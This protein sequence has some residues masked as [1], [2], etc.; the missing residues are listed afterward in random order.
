MDRL[1]PCPFCGYGGPRVKYYY[2][3]T[4]ETGAAV[5][6]PKCLMESFYQEADCVEDLI[7]GWNRRRRHE[8]QT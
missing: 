4:I 7:K 1:K 8:N 5:E 6:C 3:G 2:A